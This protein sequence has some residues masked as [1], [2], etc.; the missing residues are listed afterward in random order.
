MLPVGRVFFSIVSCLVT[1]PDAVLLAAPHYAED[2][3]GASEWVRLKP[4]SFAPL[5]ACVA[6]G[7]CL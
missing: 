2:P 5:F 4:F 3:G 1:V 6:A 7:V